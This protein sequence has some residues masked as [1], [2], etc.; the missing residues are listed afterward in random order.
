MELLEDSS[1]H[2]GALS[3]RDPLSPCLFVLICES[4]NKMVT[5]AEN[6]NLISG[7]VSTQDASSVNNLQFT[8]DTN[9]L[10][11]KGGTCNEC[12]GYPLCFEAVSGLRVNFFKIQLI[13]VGM[14]YYPLQELADLLGCKAGFLPAVIFGSS[15]M[16]TRVSKAFWNLVIER[17]KKKVSILES[18]IS[19]YYSYLINSVQSFYLLHVSL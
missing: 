4:L 2:R 7:F 11:G 14:E 6:A 9:T 5:T 10:W 8:N 3:L 12:K 17:I 13:R 18:Y 19:L 15:F 16:H 1:L